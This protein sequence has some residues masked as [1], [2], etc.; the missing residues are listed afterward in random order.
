MG[1]GV[2][3]PNLETVSVSDS[4][5]VNRDGR[6]T[7][8]PID[9]LALQLN[10][11]LNI[12][13]DREAAR[14][15]S[16]QSEQHALAAEDARDSTF[17]NADVYASTALGLA[18]TTLGGQFHVTADDASIRYRHDAG[19]IA[20]EVARY[21]S[22]AGT[23]QK[24]ADVASSVDRGVLSD[25][26]LAADATGA[27]FR[28]VDAFGQM[29]VTGLE[30][31]V[32][33][34]ILARPV[35]IEPVM[36]ATD[37]IQAHDA[38][39][40]VVLRMDE[41]GALYIPGQ[42]GSVQHGLRQSLKRANQFTTPVR[43]AR[44]KYAASVQ[45][46][47]ADL[48]A[49][50]MAYIAAPAV[51]VPNRYDVPT[52]LLSAISCSDDNPVA[53]LKFPYT[54]G[55]S[56]HPYL[57]ECREPL[58]GYRYIMAESNHKN[59]TGGEETP[60]MFGTNDLVNFDLLTDVPQPMTHS[61]PGTGGG[62]MDGYNSDPFI[63]YDPTDGS[64]IWGCR[65]TVTIG[66]VTG[67]FYTI[68]RTYD[69]VNWTP[70]EIFTLPDGFG[71]APA[72]LYDPVVELWRVWVVGGEGTLRHYTG[73][74]A[75]GPWVLSSSVNFGVV[76]GISIWHHEVKYLGG[77]FALCCHSRDGGT[78][79]KAQVYVGLSSDGDTW[80]MSPGIVQPQSPDIYKPTF[81]PEFDG[82]N[83]RL[84]FAWSHWDW[85]NQDLRPEGVPLHVQ[86]TNWVDLTAL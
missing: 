1:A 9:K 58:H 69:G 59:S 43:S 17:V 67:D 23:N 30:S 37:L 31:S 40:N 41:R 84:V 4:V 8:Q 19:P 2:K 77:Q 45:P 55:G 20:V 29:M 51:L 48:A 6:T 5:I 27:L 25:L 12:A 47:M 65:D 42:A 50:G 21:P 56:V 62:A 13:T 39:S 70:K 35:K 16:E 18:G 71:V 54:T 14:F 73:P 3:T 74:T 36:P 49:Q 57:I 60:V 53:H 38:F 72:L 83:V 15:Y 66:A 63:S 28:R 82:D 7:I 85:I 81:L 22:F 46:L 26:E 76:H 33:D 64:L 79:N 32:Q 61:S 80:T 86:Y 24:F 68:T 10:A 11:D 52:A 75:T 78:E 34:E 44:D